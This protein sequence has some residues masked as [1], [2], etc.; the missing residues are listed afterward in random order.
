MASMKIVQQFKSLT[1]EDRAAGESPFEL[2]F[3]PDTGAVEVEAASNAVSAESGAIEAFKA[4][5]FQ[6]RW[7]ASDAVA[8]TSPSDGRAGSSSRLSSLTT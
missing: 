5:Y 1:P 8:R 6:D 4:A 2:S 7:D 3:V